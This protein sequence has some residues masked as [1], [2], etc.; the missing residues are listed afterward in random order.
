MSNSTASDIPEPL[1]PFVHEAGQS[2]WGDWIR[3]PDLAQTVVIPPTVLIEGWTQD[4]E[5]N[6]QGE[7]IAEQDIVIS[8]SS[9]VKQILKLR[10]DAQWLE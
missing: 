3:Q 2:T 6:T 10:R 9:G 5:F 7:L 1:Q 8:D 4:M